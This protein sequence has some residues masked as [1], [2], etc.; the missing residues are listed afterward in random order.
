MKIDS[1]YLV[2]KMFKNIS[3][4]SVQSD[5][6]C[7]ANLGVRSCPVRKLI[8][9]VR[10]SPNWMSQ[11]CWQQIQMRLHENISLH[12][13]LPL[14]YINYLFMSM[15]S[16]PTETPSTNSTTISTTTIFGMFATQIVYPV[17]NTQYLYE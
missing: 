5:R 6:T 11:K 7:P 3:Q 10:L 1:P 4:D 2:G 15:H 16:L 12:L 8:C 17:A 9:P 13:I 14:S